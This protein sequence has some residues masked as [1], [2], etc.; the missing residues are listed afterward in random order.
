V[1]TKGRGID[2]EQR[3]KTSRWAEDILLAELNK[4]PNWVAVR[5]GLSEVKGEDE[6]AGYIKTDEKE[7][8]LLILPR[9]SLTAKQISLIGQVN[10]EEAD[11]AKLFKSGELDFLYEKAFVSIEVEFSPYKAKD[12]KGRNWVKKTQEQWNKRPLKHANPP[13][14]P[15]IFIKEEDL[16]PLITWQ[17]RHKI[18]VVITHVS[19]KKLLQFR[20]MT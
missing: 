12:M 4:Q 14:A 10:T 16:S 19:T 2:F 8:D 9:N 6:L 7:P 1:A 18:P 15:N 13:V 5:F 20:W 11:R 3:Y 17:R